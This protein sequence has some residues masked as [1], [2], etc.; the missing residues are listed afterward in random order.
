MLPGN[1][2]RQWGGGEL[3]AVAGGAPHRLGEMGGVV[4][5]AAAAGGTGGA[6]G[7]GW[8]W[9]SLDEGVAAVGAW[10]LVCQ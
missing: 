9:Q 8:G 4:G 1:G 10:G 3:G 5:G 7:G 6:L 2:G